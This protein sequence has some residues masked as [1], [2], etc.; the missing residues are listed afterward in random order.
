M[1]EECLSGVTTEGATQ[2]PSPLNYGSTWNPALV[3]EVGNCL[4]GHLRSIGIH[5]GLGPVADVVRDARWGRVEECMAE[6]PLL[7]GAMVTAYVQ[8]LQGNDPK[9][10]IVA[11][12][13]HFCAYSGSEGGRNMAPTQVGL[14]ALRDIYLPPF[15][16]AVRLGGAQSLMNAYQ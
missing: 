10:G 7:V 8:G 4:R 9:T 12:L 1:H 3:R 15:E 13:K 2:F 11:T 5:Q 16:M 6:D 14:R